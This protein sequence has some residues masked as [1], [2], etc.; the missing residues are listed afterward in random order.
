M[1]HLLTL[2]ALTVLVVGITLYPN[3]AYAQEGG[4]PPAAMNVGV[5]M[6]DG[7]RS[8]VAIQVGGTIRIMSKTTL[9]DETD[10]ITH[11]IY[12][13]P[14]VFLSDDV[15]TSGGTQDVEGIAGYI[16][17]GMYFGRV[18]LALGI[19]QLVT[20]PEEEFTVQA[21]YKAEFGYHPFAFVHVRAGVQYFDV[22]GKSNQIMP[23]GGFAFSF[24]G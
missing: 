18:S 14:S 3:P 15:D 16:M 21:A 19:G 20:K 1:K 22:A 12:Y 10:I 4:A 24:D 7:Q 5:I 11:Q 6:A 23:Y 17:G 13:E 9:V 2:F 8:S